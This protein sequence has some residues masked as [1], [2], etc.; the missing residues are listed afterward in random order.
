MRLQ[1]IS[2]PGKTVSFAEAVD[3]GIAEDGGLFMPVTIPQLP[4]DFLNSSR[5]MTFQEI[6]FRVAECLLDGEI[7]NRA[8][9][10]IVEESLTFPVPLHRLDGQTSVLE[11]FHGPTLAFKDFGARFMARTMAYL[12][13]NDALEMTILVATSGDTGSAVAHGFHNVK[14]MNVL[15]LYPSGRVSAIQEKQLTTLSG[16]VTALEVHG[17]FDDCQRLVKQAFADEGL[18]SRKKLTSANS[19]NIARLL[20]QS[21]YYFNAYALRED[22]ELPLVF[23]VPSGNLGNVAAGLLAWKMG[24]PVRRFV[25]A[26]NANRVLPRFL[27]TGM[28]IVEKSVATLSNAMDVGNPSNFVRVMHLFGNSVEAARTML[29]SASFSDDETR[30]CIRRKYTETD[31]IL[32]PHGAVGML[33]L[34]SYR[35]KERTPVQGI[36]LETA[37]PAKFLDTYERSMQAVIRTPERLR[38]SMVG[39][40]QS[41]KLSSRYEEFKEFLLS[42]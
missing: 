17:S 34:Q 2:N 12:H 10:T 37:H 28:F 6:A 36:V 23:S 11:L 42:I 26:T 27:E 24:L 14:G 39:T 5:S 22:T 20:P 9:R 8:L 1:S 3:R 38:V 30:E 16:N 35:G 19:I 33:A 29:Y 31:Y 13:R 18:S 41:V 4:R 32:D 7:P 21:F 15:L 40:K 25:A